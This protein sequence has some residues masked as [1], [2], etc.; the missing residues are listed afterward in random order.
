MSQLERNAASLGSASPLYPVPSQNGFP[1][2]S[3]KDNPGREPRR[4][5]GECLLILLAS[6]E[7]SEQDLVLAF[8]LP[9]RP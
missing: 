3:E 7:N 1:D 6:L 2:F 8:T 5:L 4:A 9:V